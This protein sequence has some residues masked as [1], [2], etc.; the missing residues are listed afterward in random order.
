ML[1]PYGAHSDAQGFGRVAS[2]GRVLGDYAISSHL[3]RWFIEMAVAAESES[4]IYL[5]GIAAAILP[6]AW[7]IFARAEKRARASCFW[8]TKP[9]LRRWRRDRHPL[10]LDRS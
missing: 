10:N 3:P 5:F 7:F 2:R 9:R 8:T 6:P 1:I 4:P